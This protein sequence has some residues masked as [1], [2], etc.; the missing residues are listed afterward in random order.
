MKKW[1]AILLILASVVTVVTRR[2]SRTVPCVTVEAAAFE[3]RVVAEG[4]LRA[5]EA[6]PIEV[7]RSDGPLVLAWLAPDGKQVAEGDVIVRFE[8]ATAEKAVREAEADLAIADT[9]LA[10]SRIEAEASARQH[11][12]ATALA[13]QQND[14]RARFQAKDPLLYTKNQIIEA[15]IDEDLA[16]ARL[17]QT[18]RAASADRKVRAADLELL[19]IARG[20]LVDWT[21]RAR[22]D[23]AHLEIRAPHAGLFVV[24]RDVT[25]IG[26]RAWN[27]EQLATLPALD[28]MEAELFVLEADGA[29]IVPGIPVELVVASHP[30][31]KFAGVVH[32]VDPIAKPRDNGVPMPYLGVVVTL[33]TTDRTIM[34]PGQ[35]VR[36]TLDLGRETAIAVPRQAVFEQDGR[37]IV[38]RRGAHG[39]APVA[40]ELGTSTAGRITVRGITNGDTI[41]L[42]DP[43][44]K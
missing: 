31:A 27:G 41:A 26:A 36:A 34:K 14:L 7:P 21:N 12:S 35:R 25:R 9:R 37:P 40:I 18:K 24:D 20:R 33:T 5:V 11:A 32:T 44:T 22:E 43:E 2:P 13:T 19:A 1:I 23:L 39:F 3:R 42:A 38:Y 28:T 30:D 15:G 8:R 16:V 29:G 6:T 10:S 4:T 17:E